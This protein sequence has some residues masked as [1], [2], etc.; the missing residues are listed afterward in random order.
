[1]EFDGDHVDGGRADIAKNVDEVAVNCKS[2][3]VGVFLFGAVVYTDAGVGGVAA[4]IGRDLFALDEDN[5]V[6]A[7]NDARD[8][9]RMTGKFLGVQFSPEFF[10]LGV[11]EEVTHFHELA[12]GIVEDG[13]E[14]VGGELLVCRAAW[15]DDVACDVAECV[16]AG[17]YCLLCDS[18]YLG[19]AASVQDGPSLGVGMASR[20][21][22]PAIC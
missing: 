21:P 5:C 12:G 22:S 2:R 7:F 8:A 4:A 9:L 11:D 17:Q 20:M 6:G 3:A 1:M 19:F 14:H 16:D 18:A 10:V 15:C 13:L